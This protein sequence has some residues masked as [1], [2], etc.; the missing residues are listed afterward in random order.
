[1]LWLLPTLYW[2][3]E[4]NAKY[5]YLPSC[6]RRVLSVHHNLIVCGHTCAFLVQL[7]YLYP[8]C[9]VSPCAMCVSC[10]PCSCN[11]SSLFLERSPVY[12]T[13]NKTLKCKIIHKKSNKIYMERNDVLLFYVFHH[14]L[15][16][17]FSSW[18]YNINIQMKMQKIPHEDFN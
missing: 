10:I 8:S 18:S 9:T 3:G 4:K 14:K 12:S 1:M 13:F 15:I 17:N 16:I 6:G 11:M 5:G 2:K 7:S